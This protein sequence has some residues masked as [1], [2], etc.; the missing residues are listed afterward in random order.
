MRELADNMPHHLRQFAGCVYPNFDP[1]ALLGSEERDQEPGRGC[2]QHCGQKP[3][4]SHAWDKH[5]QQVLEW[6]FSSGG[7]FKSGCDTPRQAYHSRTAVL[8][9]SRLAPLPLLALQAL[10]L[11]WPRGLKQGTAQLPGQGPTGLLGQ[12][13]AETRGT[14]GRITAPGR[15]TASLQQA[16][17]RQPI[18]SKPKAHCCFFFADPCNS[19]IVECAR[20]R[21]SVKELARHVLQKFALSLDAPSSLNR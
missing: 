9:S 12:N 17:R 13:P 8:R 5:R 15:I 14:G 10:S 21:A 19:K 16:T 11:E 1:K 20:A 2:Q 6:C 18:L 3:G 4:L 7:R